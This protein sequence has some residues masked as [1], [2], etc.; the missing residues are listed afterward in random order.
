MTP[1][2]AQTPPRDSLAVGQSRVAEVSTPQSRRPGGLIDADVHAVVPSTEALFPYLSAHWR[3]HVTNTLMK[4]VV[5]NAYPRY[6][7]TTARDGLETPGGPPA[8]S[9]LIRLQSDVL[10]HDGVDFAIVCCTY[11]VDSLHNPD[12]A[13][14]FAQAANDWLAAEWLERDPRLRAGIVVPVHLPELAARE[15]DRMGSHPGFVQVNLPARTTYPLGSR[16]NAPIWEAIA[17]NRLVGAIHF[18]G[19]PGTPPTPS[20]WSSYYLE[21]YAGMAHV[22]QSQVISLITEGTFDAHPDVKVAVLEAGFT[23]IGPFLWRFDKEWRNLRRLVPWVRRPP[24]EY[25]RE[26]FRFTIQP[27]DAP[28]LDDHLAQ[29][30]DQ[31][32]SERVLMYASDYP[33]RHAT[34]PGRLLNLVTPNHASR[35]RS[36]NARLLYG[37]D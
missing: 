7:P 4:G 6:A 2:I 29:A 33:H 26:H 10:D 11:Q 22:V 21:D 27:L 3:D 37:L 5:E 28:H 24:S 9:S 36:E 13:V 19:A 18:G 8:G 32:G 23:W 12:A 34:T 35:I 20:G 25:L 14:A 17:R 1:E 31:I 16:V 30:I 15:I